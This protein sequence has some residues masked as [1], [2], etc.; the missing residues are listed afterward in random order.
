MITLTV[1]SFDLFCYGSPLSY[2]SFEYL[3]IMVTLTVVTITVVTLMVT[4]LQLI[5]LWFSIKLWKFIENHIAK[6]G[7]MCSQGNKETSAWLSGNYSVAE[8]KTLQTC[9][10]K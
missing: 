3:Q 8:M 6:Y 9:R 4:I 10:Q 2:G 7:N 1:V 5:L